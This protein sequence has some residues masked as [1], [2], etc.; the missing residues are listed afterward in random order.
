MT[1]VLQLGEMVA[2][3]G[4]DNVSTEQEGDARGQVEIAKVTN[5]IIAVGCE[6]RVFFFK[7]KTAYEM[8]W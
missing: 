8:I 4:D 5:N 3:V 1:R 7:Q 2:V 6:G